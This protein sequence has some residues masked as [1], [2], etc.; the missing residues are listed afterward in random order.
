MA[1][2]VFFFC[3][4]WQNEF[5]A[6]HDWMSI[7]YCFRSIHI[8]HDN[9]FLS[10]VGS[11][12]SLPLNHRPIVLSFLHSIDLK[13]VKTFV[14][15]STALVVVHSIILVFI[16]FFF[17]LRKRQSWRQERKL[18]RR[19]KSAVGRDS[20]VWATSS[21]F[22]LSSPFCIKFF[23]CYQTQ[24]QIDLF[25][26]IT[27]TNQYTP[28]ICGFLFLLLWFHRVNVECQRPAPKKK[29]GN[30]GECDIVNSFCSE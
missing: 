15:F 17:L 25:E 4:F 8:V 11:K 24:Q 12:S 16:V 23:S 13:S 5:C 21:W 2:A 30:G 22:N 10:N 29:W 3:S 28:S 26:W 7:F 1:M 6:Y 20:I 27:S 9:F 14:K 18:S 19:S